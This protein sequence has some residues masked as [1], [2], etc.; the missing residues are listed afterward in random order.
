M[1]KAILLYGLLPMVA[2]AQ[3]A[4]QTL[5]RTPTA[6]ADPQSQYNGGDDNPLDPDDA[7]AAGGSK[8]A[9]NLSK[10]ALIAIIVVAVFVAILGIASAV[11]FW[12]AKKRQW[13]VRQS[14]RRAS[15]RF[16]GKSNVAS[17]RENRR[18]GVRLNS[19]KLPT[20]RSNRDKDLEKGVPASG[21]KGTTTTTITSQFDVD[22]P[23]TKGGWKKPTLM[24]GKK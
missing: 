15:R 2:L 5:A 21:Q 18:T 7:G 16:T 13:D 20:T 22:T 9:F 1:L 12:L 10:G 4:T 24:G 19:P 23:T 17:K 6:T 11:L 14:I 3:D 8:E